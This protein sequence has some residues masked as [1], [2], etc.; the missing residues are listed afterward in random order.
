MIWDLNG[1]RQLDFRR[2]A[3]VMGILNVTPDSFYDGGQYCDP[4]SAVDRV[5]EMAEEGADVVDVGGESSRPAIYGEAARV[6]ATEEADR[7]V[8][9]LAAVR[10]QSSIPMSI[11]TTKADVARAAL[12]AGADIINDIS[13]LGDPLMAELAAETNAPVI[14]MHRRGTAATMQQNTRYEDLLLE[15]RS[16]LEDRVKAAVDA[17]AM[18]ERLA[19]DPGVGFGKSVTGNFALIRHLSVFARSRHPIVVGASR[20]SFLWKPFG[21]SPEEALAGSLAAAALAVVNGANI[22]RAHDVAAT[23]RAIQVVEAIASASI[24]TGA[25]LES[26][27]SSLRALQPSNGSGLG[28]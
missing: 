5:L 19:L 6:P 21:L 17:G 27:G 15:I 26:E 13:A 25:A 11:D 24:T 14:L 22:I 12:D 23:T 3:R 18:A 10:R 7:V 8:P 4:E 1:G 9:V 16:F 2:G 28:E 20:K